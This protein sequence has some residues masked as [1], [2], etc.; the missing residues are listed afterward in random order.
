MPKPAAK[1]ARSARSAR[2]A[3]PRAARPRPAPS[4]APEG[5]YIFTRK[6][7]REVDRVAA[8]EFGMPRLLLMEN[9][10]RH[11]ADI[12]L[13]L[14]EEADD[15]FAMIFCGPGNNG[16]DGLALARHLHNAGV[17]V[18]ILLAA[19]PDRYAGE[20]ATNLRIVE[21]MGLPILSVG[22]QAGDPRGPASTLA[23]A[24]E[25]LR[26][27]HLVVDALLGT[28]PERPIDEPLR[29]LIAAVND[30]R[31]CGATVLAVD[32]P[33]GLDCD[34]GE[35]LGAAV[36]ADVTV[37]F[38]GLKAGFT[39]SAALAYIGD[40]VVADVGAPRE[41]MERLGVPASSGRSRSEPQTRRAKKPV[42][43][44]P[45]T[46]KGVRPRAGRRI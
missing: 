17:G 31:S 36:V 8:D 13:D 5:L 29:S 30:W 19:A 40:V 9:A 44:R 32:L 20:A 25:E 4:D 24:T 26:T 37:T 46:G 22:G 15:P 28:G 23:R 18:C 45:P 39:R 41:I 12:S 6:A 43:T 3:K 1:P 11:L 7:A 27:P 10:A 33:S 34:T 16:G 42:P 2:A 35:P 14:L 38:V 21:A